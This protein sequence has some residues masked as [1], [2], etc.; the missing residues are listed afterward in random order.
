VITAELDPLRD[1]AE[2]YAAR[3][4]QAGVP[5]DLRRFDGVPHGFFSKADRFDAGAEAQE[6]VASA[7]RIAFAASPCAREDSNLRPAD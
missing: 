5:V 1:Q 7:L 3:L 4:G 2:L 6:V